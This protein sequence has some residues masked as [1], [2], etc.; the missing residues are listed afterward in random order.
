MTQKER[1]II[2]SVCDYFDYHNK[3]LNK[4]Q[5]WKIYELKQLLKP[6]KKTSWVIVENKTACCAWCEKSFPV[7]EMLPQKSSGEYFCSDQCEKQYKLEHP[8]AE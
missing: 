1:E 2:Q 6:K 8:V 3:N 7:R 5:D 4:E